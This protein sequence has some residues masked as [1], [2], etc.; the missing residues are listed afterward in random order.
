L[1]RND[2]AVRV[3][4]YDALAVTSKLL[5]PMSLALLLLL[6]LLLLLLLDFLAAVLAVC[7]ICQLPLH[8]M[9]HGL[10]L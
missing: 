6:E 9:Y 4:T 2:I 1:D 8:S 10:R 7:F 3:L 5:L